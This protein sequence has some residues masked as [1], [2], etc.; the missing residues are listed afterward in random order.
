MK[1]TYPKLTWRDYLFVVIATV[2]IVAFLICV[3][4]G[5]TTT[6]DRS[7]YEP[8]DKFSTTPPDGTIVGPLKDERKKEGFDFFSGAE[9]KEF[10]NLKLFNLG[11]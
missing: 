3:L 6:T 9:G 10:L 11:L 8:T 5:C 2:I 4:P 7:Y 1:D